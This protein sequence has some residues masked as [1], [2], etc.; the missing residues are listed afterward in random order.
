[1]RVEAVGDGAGTGWSCVH[2]EGR[3]DGLEGPWWAGAECPITPS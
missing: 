3:A 2:P 1:M